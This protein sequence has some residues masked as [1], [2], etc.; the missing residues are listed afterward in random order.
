VLAE[1]IGKDGQHLLLCI[2]QSEASTWLEKA[3]AIVTLRQVWEQQYDLEASPIQWHPMERLPPS[4]ER[5]AS[6][7]DTEARYSTKRSVTWFGY[8]VHLTETCDQETPHLIGLICAKLPPS[9]R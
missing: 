1:Q 7:H 2:I 8:K 5:I 6:P 9:A 4:S 3:P